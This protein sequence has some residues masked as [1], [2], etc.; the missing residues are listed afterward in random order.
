MKAAH[1]HLGV[2]DLRAALKW[3]DEVWDL[4]PT[5][6]NESMA[7][8]PFGGL[9]IILDAAAA[10]TAATVAFESQNCDEDFRAVMSRG[11]RA[12]EQ[13]LEQPTDRPWGARS[14]YVRGPGALTFE[15]EQLLPPHG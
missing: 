4:R 11:A 7:T 10:D 9:S 5:F 13:A 6:E 15:I 2:T 12:L 1:V 14:A 8:L 3:L